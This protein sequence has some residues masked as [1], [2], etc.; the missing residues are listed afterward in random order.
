M[1]KTSGKSEDLNEAANRLLSE[2][3]FA[4]DGRPKEQFSKQQETFEQKIVHN[5]MGN[6]MR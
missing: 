4:T 6:R 2:N 5:A 1:Q 3:G